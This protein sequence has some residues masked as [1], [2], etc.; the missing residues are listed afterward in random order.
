MFLLYEIVFLLLLES[1]GPLPWLLGNMSRL[2]VKSFSAIG[3]WEGLFMLIVQKNMLSGCNCNCFP[4]FV[5]CPHGYVISANLDILSRPSLVELISRS[6]KFS[7]GSLSHLSIEE[8][9]EKGLKKFANKQEELLGVQ[10]FLSEWK[11][12]V[13]LFVQKRTRFYRCS[14]MFLQFS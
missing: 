5:D 14:S 7:R 9:I 4:M 10:G 3:R 1:F 12:K 13:L 11:A 2:L 8:A 6:T